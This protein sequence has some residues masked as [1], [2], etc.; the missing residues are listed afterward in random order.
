MNDDGLLADIYSN[1]LPGE[2]NNCNGFES[3]ARFF[4]HD[5]L[6]RPNMTSADL[7]LLMT[8]LCRWGCTLDAP[9]TDRAGVLDPDPEHIADL[10]GVPFGSPPPPSLERLGTQD[11][12]TA[13]RLNP[14]PATVWAIPVKAVGFLY[15]QAAGG[16]ALVHIS[17]SERNDGHEDDF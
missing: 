10:F 2:P 17:L 8:A 15:L 5:P 11:L 3:V 14:T 4:D 16:E 1:W 9:L 7:C 6:D 13:Y 12:L